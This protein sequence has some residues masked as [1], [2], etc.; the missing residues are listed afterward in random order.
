MTGD[1]GN[2]RFLKTFAEQFRMQL[3][4]APSSRRRVHSPTRPIRRPTHAPTYPPVA[5]FFCLSP[6]LPPLTLSPS[7]PP[8]PPPPPPRTAAPPRPNGRRRGASRRSTRAAHSAT[9]PET[10]FQEPR[11]PDPQGSGRTPTHTARGGSAGLKGGEAP[12]PLHHSAKTPACDPPPHR[13][14]T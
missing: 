12:S 7:L 6:V 5:P 2:E 11:P 3:T 9:Q 1:L 10:R 13:L 14:P 8:P 4:T